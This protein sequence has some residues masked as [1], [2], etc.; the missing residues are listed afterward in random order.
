[1]CFE[2]ESG[3]LLGL[4]AIIANSP[5][6]LNAIAQRGSIVRYVTRED[7]ED[8]IRVEPSLLVMVFQVLA[9]EVLAARHALSGF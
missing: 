5:Y 9:A 4:P 3:S 8:L 6:S 2:A 1:M 7:F